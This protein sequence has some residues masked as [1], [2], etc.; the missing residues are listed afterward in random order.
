VATP[1][2]S[3]SAGYQHYWTRTVRST[4]SYGNLRINN[5]A[6]DPGTNYHVS[7]YATGNII[8]QHSVP[9][10]CVFA[11]QKRF[12]VDRTSYSVEPD[13][14]LE[15]LLSGVAWRWKE[16]LETAL[17]GGIGWPMSLARKEKLFFGLGYLVGL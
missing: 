8:V 15:Q 14:L 13:F 16:S 10:Q 4:A 12:P 3:A 6:A 1:T 11:A 2:W 5:T 17:F 7:N 9:Y